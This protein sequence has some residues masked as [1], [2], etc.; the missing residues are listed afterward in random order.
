MGSTAKVNYFDSVWLPYWINQHDVLWLQVS[1]DQTQL[2][3]TKKLI[4]AG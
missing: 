1:M 4:Q 2:L 3:K